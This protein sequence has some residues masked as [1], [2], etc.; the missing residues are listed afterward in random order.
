ME[1]M[2]RDGSAPSREVRL[3]YIRTLTDLLR[4]T[5]HTSNR[6]WLLLTV[7]G[8]FVMA[9]SLNVVSI[10]ETVGVLGAE[11][12][13]RPWI[14]YAGGTWLVGGLW[15]YGFGL[16]LHG[17]ALGSTILSN[18]EDL[19]FE[20]IKWDAMRHELL[21]FPGFFSITFGNSRFRHTFVSKLTEYS[22][23]I[24][25][26]IL[27]SLFPVTVQSL[28]TVEMAEQYGLSSFVVLVQGT[29]ILVSTGYVVT[30]WGSWKDQKRRW[31]EYLG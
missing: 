19:G 20:D 12:R 30:A 29:S 8:L 9:L 18:Y 5:A 17:R 21:A 3:Q 14:I 11:L 24:I 23:K 27:I 10:G 25:V 15:M 26:A 16:E 28:A 22:A 2:D 6:V 4:D 1:L 31:P 7:V 13:L